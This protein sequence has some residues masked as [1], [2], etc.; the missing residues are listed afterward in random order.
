MAD[1][2]D[3]ASDP[4][5]QPN[6]QPAPKQ[7]D[8]TI[9]VKSEQATAQGDATWAEVENAMRLAD[10]AVSGAVQGMADTNPSSI[11]GNHK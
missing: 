3:Q 11:D 9:P 1:P 8:A 2:A 7:D 10:D 4:P 6:A 5:E